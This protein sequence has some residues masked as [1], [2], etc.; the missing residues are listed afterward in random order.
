MVWPQYQQSMEDGYRGQTV[1]VEHWSD[2]FEEWSVA[3][4]LNGQR[5]AAQ[6]QR[7]GSGHAR[8]WNPADPWCMCREV[9]HPDHESWE[10]CSANDLLQFEMELVLGGSDT[11]SETMS[12]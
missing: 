8:F 2:D 11:E 9:A 6:L 7:H 10:E 12:E 4:A 5:I 3:R 1:L